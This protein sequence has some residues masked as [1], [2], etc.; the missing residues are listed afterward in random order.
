MS[1]SL[2]TSDI[3]VV[4]DKGEGYNVNIQPPDQ[5][6]VSIK[7]G[8]VYIVNIDLPT[9][10]TNNADTYYR[11]A[12]Y[13]YTANTASYSVTSSFALNVPPLPD[14][15]VSSSSQINS[16]SFSGS[17]IGDGSQLTGIATDLSF[18]GDIGSSSINLKT[19]ALDIIGSNGIQTIVSG[20]T[21]E[22]IAPIGTVSSSTQ[23]DYTQLQNQPT[24]IPTASYVEF[25]N[26]AN[27]PEL[28][29]SSQQIVE[30]INNQIITPA[31][32]TAS[33]QSNTIAVS[34]NSPNTNTIISSSVKSGIFNATEI[35]EP[36]IPID[37]FIGTS[38]EYTAQRE[39]AVRS[40]FLIASWSGSS[41]T[42]TDVSNADVGDTSDLS[43]NFIRVGDMAL[44]RAYSAGI[45]S[46]AWTVQVLFKMF[47][48]LL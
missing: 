41:I 25:D 18:T 28:V 23:V 47:P 48:N 30:G 20:N 9:V 17:F 22:L 35:L 10:I 24:V 7:S 26:I 31:Q 38:V 27:K 43:F 15:I 42:Y 34:T 19:T 1:G 8:D 6:G 4:I 33:I 36:A 12:D 39:T 13:A 44:L 14:G 29:S 45:G 32:V 2:D 40:G 3:L 16:G 21:I 46:G 5:Y 37:K 11:V